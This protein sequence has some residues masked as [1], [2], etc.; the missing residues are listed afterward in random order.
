MPQMIDL[1]TVAKIASPI[2]T[3][4]A[5]AVLKHYAEKSP[6]VLSYIGHVSS[7]TL[8]DEQKS[9]VFTHSVIVRNAGRKS[10]TN[11]RLGHHFLPTN[12]RIDPQINYSIE[13][14]PEGAAEIVIPTLVPKEQVTISYLYFPPTTWNQ[15][16]SYT[17]S[18]DGYA[19]IVNVVPM[20]QPSIPVLWL[21]RVLI[22]IGASFVTYWVL[23]LVFSLI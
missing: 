7:F 4:I 3:L 13:K 17:K 21:S 11:V 15:I 6:K 9:F 23:R 5:G 8:Q 12:L 22:L 20:L 10:A 14:N 18:D 2:V 16:N 1:E 19:K